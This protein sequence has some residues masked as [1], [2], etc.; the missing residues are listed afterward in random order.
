MKQ[1]YIFIRLNTAILMKI[2]KRV[3]KIKIPGILT[4]ES[5]GIFY[6][7]TFYLCDLPGNQ[8]IANL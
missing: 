3:F 2:C 8:P 1:I 6:F 7:E 4:N 5:P